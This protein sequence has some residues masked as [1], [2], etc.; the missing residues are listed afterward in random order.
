[1]SL[2]SKLKEHAWTSALTGALAVVGAAA[3]T[4][5]V[6]WAD[7]RYVLFSDYSTDQLSRGV[8]VIDMQI[9]QVDY[10]LRDSAQQLADA[11][12]DRDLRAIGQAEADRVFFTAEKDT[13]LRR[14]T[15]ML[16]SP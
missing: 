1:M 14:R 3:A 13:L 8:L 7:G 6:T 15:D 5:A 2:L 12:A 16:R 4:G 11:Q 10:R 9:R